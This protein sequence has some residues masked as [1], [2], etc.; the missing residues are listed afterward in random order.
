MHDETFSIVLM[1]EKGKEKERKNRKEKPTKHNTRKNLKEQ[2]K[3]CMAYYI[4]LA[5]QN[6]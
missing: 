3:S 6:L 5:W 2:E 4:Y 1:E